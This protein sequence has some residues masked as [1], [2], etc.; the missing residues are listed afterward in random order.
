MLYTIGH[1]TLDQP[2]FLRIL[3]SANVDC[4]MD[5]RS[6]PQSRWPWFHLEQMRHWIPETGID[7]IWEPRLGGWR[8][9]DHDQA[10]W[11]WRWGVDVT[12]YSGRGF[13]KQRI[14]RRIGPD[15]DPACP[16]HGALTR[17]GECSCPGHQPTWTVVGF[18]D[19][20]L[21]MALP[22]F[23]E[24][25]ADVAV[26][27]RQRRIAIMCQEGRWFSCHRSMIAD[28]MWVM[29]QIDSLHLPSRSKTHSQMLGNRLQRYPAV[30]WDSWGK[31]APY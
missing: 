3:H 9:E 23:I 11:A 19:Y 31:P 15:V 26:Q 1:S 27:V 22:K 12:A 8:D 4:L 18:W 20:A 21:Y 30:C 2:H 24:G 7:Y 5:V 6:H 10:E 29:H 28:A 16:Q 13:P 14:T 25:L 17:A